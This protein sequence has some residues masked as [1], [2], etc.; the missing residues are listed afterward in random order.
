MR[1]ARYDESYGNDPADNYERFF[2]PTIGEPF[3]R[4]LVAQADIRPSEH[5]LDVACGTG[6]VARLITRTP[7]RIGN[8]TGL[9]SNASM[10]AVAEAVTIPADAVEWR[11]APAEDM[12]FPDASFDVVLCQ[13]GLQFMEDLA[14]AL[15][16]MRRVSRPGGRVLVS[17]PGPIMGVFTPLAD[18]LDHH[19]GPEVG[20]FVRQVFSLHD[21]DSLRGML[22]RAGFVDVTV[23]ATKYDLELPTSHDFLWQYIHCTPLTGVM[24]EIGADRVAAL[25][26][27]VIEAWEPFVVDAG[28]K[29]RQ[30]LV[31]ASANAVELGLS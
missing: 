29:H 25:E 21:V 23:D 5:V 31:V 2:V 26:R 18:A 9:D 14:G 16:E 6:V 1:H 11:R 4:A 3:A 8:V 22:E 13:M 20:A 28:L 10:L 17:V 30:R 12:P 15:S 24:S 27:D 19:V 7:G